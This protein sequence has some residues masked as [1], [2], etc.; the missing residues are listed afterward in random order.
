MQDPCLLHVRVGS[1]SDGAFLLLSRIL[2]QADAIRFSIERYN[3][4]S[5]GYRI[6]ARFQVS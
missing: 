5:I 4:P 6:D 1:A 2:G 3:Q